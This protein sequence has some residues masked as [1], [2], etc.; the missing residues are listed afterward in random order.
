M[1]EL[2]ITN[3]CCDLVLVLYTWF[4]ELSFNSFEVFEWSFFISNCSK[5][6]NSVKYESK[7]RVLVL[8]TSSYDALHIYHVSFFKHK[9]KLAILS[10]ERTCFY[11]VVSSFQVCEDKLRVSNR[12]FTL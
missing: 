7:V 10:G 1:Y 11:F 8:C 9:F 6:H 3:I 5:G 4:P 12:V 2:F